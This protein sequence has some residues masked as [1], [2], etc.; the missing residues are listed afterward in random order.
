MYYFGWYDQNQ[1]SN[2]IGIDKKSYRNIIYCIG[3]LASNRV[4]PLY[5]II[6]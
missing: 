2:S 1:K 3:Y 6:N 5:L 4:K